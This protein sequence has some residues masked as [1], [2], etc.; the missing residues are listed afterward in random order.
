MTELKNLIII[1]ITD[2]ETIVLD[3][4]TNLKEIK[5]R[6]KILVKNISQKSRLWNLNC[7]LKEILDTNLSRVL[8][9]GAVNPGQEFA[10]EYEIQKLNKPCLKVEEIFDSER[11]INNIV[12]N[13]FLYQ[14]IN[15]S[16]LKIN[17]TNMLNIPI[18]GIKVSREI[19]ELFQEIQIQTPGIGKAEVKIEDSKK[20]INWDVDSIEGNQ[21][22]SLEVFCTVNPKERKDISLGASKITYLINQHKLT[23]L[24]P[25]IRGLTDSMSGIST[26]ESSQPGVWECNVEFINESEFKVRLENVK[27]SHKIPSGSE[28]II[29]E[30]P[31]K[32]LNPN[33]SWDADFKIE[34]SQNVPELEAEIVFTPLFG[35]ITRVIGEINKEPTFYRVLSAE[36]HKTINPPE[37]AAYASTEMSIIDTINNLGTSSINDLE[38]SDEIPVDFVPPSMKEIKLTVKNVN[39]TFEIQENAEFVQIIEIE[40]SDQNPDSKHVISVKLKNLKKLI[41]PNSEL[42]MSYPLLAKNPKPEVQYN[43]QIT[44]KANTPIKGK[45]F[46]IND[47]EEP[48]INIKYVQRK[49]KTLKSIKPGLNAGEFSISVRIQNK[50]DVELENIIVKDKIPAG[51]TLAETNFDLPYK[52]TKKGA[53]SELEVKIVELKGNQSMNINYNCSGSG[54]YPRFEPSVVVK[55]RGE[56]ESA[57]GSNA[58]VSTPSQTA[59]VTTASQKKKAK[60]NEIFSNLSKKLD[61]TITG[62]QLGNFIEEMRDDFPP[63]PVLHQFMQFAKDM[64]SETNLIVGALKDNI[65]AKIHDFKEK[66]S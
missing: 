51:F 54:D 42:I 58:Q 37:V 12:N 29:S 25:E 7:D 52:I 60:L 1:D 64:K 47:L 19:P 63:G 4:N 2:N 28:M 32:E 3:D 31:N 38:I 36:V 8:N 49:L 23:N 46:I 39:D 35:I 33:E 62:T 27:V 53:E 57:S 66:Y 24:D 48:K 65:A 30:T 50:G 59:S 40:P 56:A 41:P 34:E 11:E 10:Q 16:S 61:E 45:D 9:V 22:A 17:L 18:S 43:T 14:N 20:I 13:A 21:T 5:G 15:K 55:G 6:G 44:I 26:D